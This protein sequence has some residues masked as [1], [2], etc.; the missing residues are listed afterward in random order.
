MKE[1]QHPLE[2]DTLKKLFDIPMAW[3]EKN[4]FLRS[5]RYQYGRFGRLT[6]KQLEAF[7]KT[8]KDMKTQEKKT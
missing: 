5:V 8:L 7:K 3:Y 1:I 2:D 4:P 6:D